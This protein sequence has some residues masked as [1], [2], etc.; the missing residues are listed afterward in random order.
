MGT[1]ESMEGNPNQS[2]AKPSSLTFSLAYSN[3]MV[4]SLPTGSKAKEI[5]CIL[6]QNWV[7]VTEKERM[8]LHPHA[9]AAQSSRMFVISRLSRSIWIQIT[10]PLQMMEIYQMM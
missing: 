3:F 7:A 9:S 6:T 5:F 4:S 1:R 2:L 8:Y 10:S